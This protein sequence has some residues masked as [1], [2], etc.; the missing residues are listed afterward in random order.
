MERHPRESF[1]LAT[2]LNANAAS[3]KEDA[4]RQL[5]VSLERTGAGYFDFYLLHALGKGN[6]DKY[7]SWGLWDFIKEKKAEGKLRHIGFSFHDTPEMLDE[8]LTAHPEVE[9]VQLQI[10]YADWEA[11][12]VQS[13]ACYEVA[14]KHG[15]PVVVMEPVK[16]GTLAVPPTRVQ[17][18]LTEANPDA[19]F[20]SWAIRFVASQEGILTVLSGMSNLEQMEDNLSYMENFKPLDDAEKAVIAK[21][22]AALNSVEQIPCTGCAYCTPGCPMQIPIPDIFKAMN[23]GLIYE[24]WEGP[25]KMYARMAEKGSVAS[26]CIGCGQCE[27]VCPQHIG[28]IDWLA[29]CAERLGE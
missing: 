22:Q 2:K 9:F 25:K 21:A 4:E 3:G 18:V 27:S 1:Y 19:S 6:I 20:A 7:N 11:P 26:D 15:K 24:D 13:R 5:E 16:G 28:I 17:E 14:R 12:N 29:K 10:N 23:R 8:L